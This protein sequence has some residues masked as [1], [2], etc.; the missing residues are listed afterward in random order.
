MDEILA[1]EKF[2]F[3][4]LTAAGYVLG[5]ASR[6]FLVTYLLGHGLP[7]PCRSYAKTHNPSD[8]ALP[9]RIQGIFHGGVGH[10]IVVFLLCKDEFHRLPYVRPIQ[11][12]KVVV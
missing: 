12:Q 1:V 4:I 10:P 6:K 9:D 11:V 3:H 2:I 8:L 5:A 7:S